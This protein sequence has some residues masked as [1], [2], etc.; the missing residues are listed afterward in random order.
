MTDVLAIVGST[1][2]SGNDE[3]FTRAREL[4]ERILSEQW[5]DEV[6]SGGAVGIDKL[7]VRIAHSM[8]IP[9]QEFLP[10]QRRWAPNW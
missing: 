1:D 4:I 5:P 6:I 7:A 3:G 9:T 10:K 8:R 2:W